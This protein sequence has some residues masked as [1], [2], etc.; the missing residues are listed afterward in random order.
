M[1]WLRKNRLTRSPFTIP[2]ARKDPLDCRPSRNGRCD[3]GGL[4]LDQQVK[5]QLQQNIDQFRPLLKQQFQ[6]EDK[7]VQQAQSDP[8]R[9]VQT[10]SKKSGQDEQQIEQ[11]LLQLVRQQSR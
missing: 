11:Q 9:L 2:R 4:M 8:D 1:A 3:E 5:Q 7:D 6:L 10:I